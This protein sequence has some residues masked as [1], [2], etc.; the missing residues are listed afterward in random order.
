MIRFMIILSAAIAAAAHSAIADETVRYQA[1]LREAL[2]LM[3][4]N[5]ESYHLS[6]GAGTYD[7]TTFESTGQVLRISTDGKPTAY[8][9]EFIATYD[10]ETEL[11]T[12]AYDSPLYETQPRSATLAVKQ[13]ALDQQWPAF[14]IDPEFVNP[15]SCLARSA[16][17]I[18]LSDI[19]VIDGLTLEDQIHYFGLRIPRPTS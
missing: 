19:D 3:Q 17:T 12:A 13:H 7:I 5:F 4:S 2:N 6:V 1:A 8:E 9:A 10:T 16:L 18:T 11:C 14:A 15:L